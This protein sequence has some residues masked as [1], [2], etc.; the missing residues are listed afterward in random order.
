MYACI[1]YIIY[2]V[3]KMKCLSESWEEN[4]IIF[5]Q[6]H[7]KW[8]RNMENRNRENVKCDIFAKNVWNMRK[9]FTVTKCRV[10]DFCAGT[11]ELTMNVYC[12][13]MYGMF[14]Q[15]DDLHYYCYRI[16]GRWT[17]TSWLNDDYFSMIHRFVSSFSISCFI[18]CV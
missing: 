4:I 15:I 12:Y 5:G 1:A 10:S 13:F 2:Y 17:D 11:S 16:I 18:Y 7:I 6:W 9:L 3:W 14:I 8:K